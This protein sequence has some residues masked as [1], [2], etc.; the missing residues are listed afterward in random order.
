MLLFQILYNM[1]SNRPQSICKGP[2]N[3]TI[4]YL[5]EHFSNANFFLSHLNLISYISL[6]CF[7]N[8]FEF[9]E[10]ILRKTV[11]ICEIGDQRVNLKLSNASLTFLNQMLN[12]LS[13]FQKTIQHLCGHEN[14]RQ[15]VPFQ[16]NRICNGSPFN[17]LDFNNY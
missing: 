7:D 13:E 9:I 4:R 12:S 10:S 11:V 3:E 8:K 1:D 5:L 16:H 17:I 2:S 6:K 15:N 14:H